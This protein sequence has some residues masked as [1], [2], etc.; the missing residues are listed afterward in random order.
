VL[1][2]MAILALALCSQLHL[3]LYLRRCKTNTRE[4]SKLTLKEAL[5]GIPIGRFANTAKA[6]FIAGLLK[7]KLCEISWIARNKFWLAVAPTTY[8]VR[9]NFHESNGVFCRRYAHRT[10]I[11]TTRATTYF[12]RGSGPQ[13]F[14]TWK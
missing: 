5:Y 10:W 12:V 7:A 3:I 4:I 9:K 11:E 13:S 14:V 1:G 6:L 8:A 2:G